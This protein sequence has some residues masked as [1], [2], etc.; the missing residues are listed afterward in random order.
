MSYKRLYEP[1]PNQLKVVRKSLE[2]GWSM[3]VAIAKAN[4][5]TWHWS[6]WRRMYPEVKELYEIGRK[7]HEQKMRIRYGREEFSLKSN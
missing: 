4:I 2:Q 6:K 3:P 7:M 5:S 1:Q